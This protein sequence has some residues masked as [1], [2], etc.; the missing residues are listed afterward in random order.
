M[1]TGPRS[2]SHEGPE[3]PRRAPL[4]PGA[5]PP[6]TGRPFSRTGVPAA[7][8]RASSDRES[9]Q[10]HEPIAPTDE[11]A[12]GLLDAASDAIVSLD[13]DGRITYANAAAIAMSRKPIDA[14][15][16]NIVWDVFP[17]LARGAF[18]GEIQETLESGLPRHALIHYEPYAIWADIRFHPRPG[19]VV[20]FV[21]DVTERRR[22][23]ET[24]TL[25]AAII[26]EVHNAI[27]AAD[28]DGRVTSWN[29]GAEEL[30][31]WTADEVLGRAFDEFIP[32]TT[33]SP[34]ES[35]TTASEHLTIEQPLR[36][37]DGR[38]L[39]ILSSRVPRHDA[40][41]GYAGWVAVH[42]DLTERRAAER[43]VMEARARMELLLS[44]GPAVIYS[45]RPEPGYPSNFFSQ[46]ARTVLGLEPADLD[47]ER[48][49]ARVHPDD[50]AR[51]A[52]EVEKIVEQGHFVQEY[53][54]LHGDGVYRWLRDEGR[55]LRAADGAPL[56]TVGYLADIT[57]QRIAEVER[58]RL[59]AAIDQTSDGVILFDEAGTP[60]YANTSL[61]RITGHTHHEIL[62]SQMA[63][64]RDFDD[65][66]NL[67][68]A[69]EA[70][71]NAGRWRGL[72]RG[73]RPDGSAI[74]VEMSI[75]PLTDPEGTLLNVV[76]TMRD[77]TLESGL[78][79]A[80][81]RHTNERNE[82]IA[83]LGRIRPG[84][85]L[86]D[87]A[88]A[89]LKEVTRLDGLEVGMVFGFVNGV[90][91]LTLATDGVALDDRPTRELSP[92]C[93]RYLRRRIEAGGFLEDAG[94]HH[95]R[96]ADS[97]C[98]WDRFGLTAMQAIRLESDGVLVG[99]LA[100]GAT[101]ADGMDQLVSIS[102]LLH[103]Y[104]A[105]ASALLAPG[106]NERR[107]ASDV[108]AQLESIIDG[109]EFSAVIQ[110]VVELAT[111]TVVGHEALTRFLDG[112]RPDARFAQA[113]ALGLGLELEE[114]TLRNSLQSTEGMAAGR[115]L[116]LNVSSAMVLSGRLPAILKLHGGRQIV[117]EI[118]EH[119]A[120]DDYAA[121]RAAVK[122]L[123]ARFHLAVDDA[124][125]G[126][127]SLRHIVELRPKYVKLD[128]GLVRG[129]NRDPAR[130]GLIAGMVHFAAETSCILI[131]EGIETEAERRTLR[132]LGVTFGQGYLLGR[133]VPPD[134][135]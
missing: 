24:L 87:T 50:R 131:A 128:A 86:E 57:Q 79:A 41:G 113:E 12:A 133:P 71:R 63:F 55:L 72:L 18:L 123:G 36:H 3:L 74:D 34:E 95:A 9:A 96:H 69:V 111:R 32:S 13:Q 82:L 20:L 98:S 46:S 130:Q 52:A 108:S 97:E 1:I 89:I 92:A 66:A 106:I 91:V 126:F 64:V 17:T 21:R 94:L 45:D 122:A 120:I 118:T 117:L 23:E 51:V 127:S 80:V 37:R 58:L 107:E 99:A 85:T 77:V 83:S 6:R 100:V 31:G 70:L 88:A 104:G 11:S 44:V 7:R 132:R 10:G 30:Y 15:I 61:E 116:S 75:W 38:T 129:V 76:A 8:R 59:A 93:A 56:E 119:A 29:R 40:D 60:V 65:N 2:R 135:E 16:G 43:E 53:R 112:E 73:V 110:P 14:L 5:T 103:E 84:P 109:R 78:T 42:T 101:R 35:A 121:V 28:V 49:I 27:I 47:G 62:A 48:F 81:E 114:A 26:N 134:S 125:A 105:L 67:A 4:T 25:Q 54:F 19:G 39:W 68:A 102:S 90:R 22:S 115:W 124:G 33:G